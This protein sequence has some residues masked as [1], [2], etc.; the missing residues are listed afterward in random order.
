M[1]DKI[2]KFC[3]D[4]KD[5]LNG[6]E[7]RIQEIK[8]NIATSRDESLAAVTA[9]L[10]KAR[11]DIDHAKQDARATK[12][13]PRHSTRHTVA[14]RRQVTLVCA[15]HPGRLRESYRSFPGGSPAA[16]NCQASGSAFR[17]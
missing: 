11:A 4:L 8:S 17:G 3:D 1:S 13:H 7:S 6:V 10:D 5:R 12:E 9:K 2:D 16:G 14:Q 15:S